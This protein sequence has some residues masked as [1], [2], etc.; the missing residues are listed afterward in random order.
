[1]ALFF[2]EIVINIIIYEGLLHPEKGYFVVS[3]FDLTKGVKKLNKV[4]NVRNL[5]NLQ[6]VF[7]FRD[8][9]TKALQN[10]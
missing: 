2:I 1:M 7:Q 4:C 5:K 10:Y 8:R 6:I 9:R 3:L